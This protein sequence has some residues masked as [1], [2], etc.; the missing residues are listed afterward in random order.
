MLRFMDEQE[1]KAR[2]PLDERTKAASR[3]GA[4]SLTAVQE[5]TLRDIIADPHATLRSL[6]EK[7]DITIHA[8]WCRLKSLRRKG[9]IKAGTMTS[10]FELAEEFP[11]TLD[12]LAAFCPFCRGAVQYNG[13]SLYACSRCGR[14]FTL[15]E[16]SE[17]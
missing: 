11:A 14:S 15:Y 13:R 12:L 3:P 1:Q 4:S 7:Y 6:C 9:W 16:D 5:A 10:G 17:K 2:G 8:V